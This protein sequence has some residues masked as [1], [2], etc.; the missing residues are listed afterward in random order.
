MLRLGSTNTRQ[1]PAIRQDISLAATDSSSNVMGLV[2]ERREDD[3]RWDKEREGNEKK[4]VSAQTQKGHA[5]ILMKK[6]FLLLFMLM[7][8]RCIQGGSHNNISGSRGGF[9]K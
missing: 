2:R 5:L 1:Y 6:H 8:A 3:M 9:L 7:S 4:T